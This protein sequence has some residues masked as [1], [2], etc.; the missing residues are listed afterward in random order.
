MDYNEYHMPDI[1]NAPHANYIEKRS[2]SMAIASMALAIAGLV[3]GCCVYPAI[4]FGS[5]AIILALLSRGGEMTTNGYAKAGLI[6]GSIA[7]I[8]GILFLIY[9]LTVLFIQ[10][11]GLEGY[12]NYIEELMEKMGDPSYTNPYDMYQDIYQDMYQNL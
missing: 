10:F 8:F 12:M 7:I 9:S 4:I 3:M 6:L 11:G 2:T 1:P 5:L